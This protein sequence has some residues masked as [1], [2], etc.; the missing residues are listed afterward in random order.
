MRREEGRDWT[1]YYKYGTGR[2]AKREEGRETGVNDKNSIT[3]MALL[4]CLITAQAGGGDAGV[5]GGGGQ[6]VGVDLVGGGGAL[7]LAEP[8]RLPDL[9]HDPG[10]G[11]RLPGADHPSSFVHNAPRPEYPRLQP[12]QCSLMSHCSLTNA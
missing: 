1:L 2:I 11:P 4:I 3:S 9:P 12:H 10:T 5:P 6:G 7:D 8:L